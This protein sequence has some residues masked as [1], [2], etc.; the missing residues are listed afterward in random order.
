METAETAVASTSSPD[1]SIE[2]EM[3]EE[4]MAL[5]RI[6]HAMESFAGLA[7]LETERW[8]RNLERL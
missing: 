8:A 1:D 4:L 2:P 7:S 5:G 6:T 3:K